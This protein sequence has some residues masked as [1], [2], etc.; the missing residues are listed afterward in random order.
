VLKKVVSLS[1]FFYTGFCF[2]M[3]LNSDGP[4]QFL[5]APWRNNYGSEHKPK[6]T[7]NNQT[8]CPLCRNVNDSDDRKNFIL[9]R[10]KHTIIQLNLFPYN[11]GHILI[12]PISHKRDLHEFTLEEQCELIKLIGES[13]RILQE[14]LKSDGVNIGVNI[15]K[16]A[17]ASIPNH[18]HIHVLPRWQDDNYFLSMLAQTRIISIDLNKMYEILKPK[19]ESVQAH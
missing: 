14:S 10:H 12:V 13:S 15:G 5:Y 8:E 4:T 9:L 17:G 2:C 16:P 18:L 1:L 3:N 7:V 19:F 11:K 6:D